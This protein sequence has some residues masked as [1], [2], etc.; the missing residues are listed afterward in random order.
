MNQFKVQSIEIT[1]DYVD[2]FNY[3]SN[4]K[5]LP[6]WT[7]AFDSV[8]G[9]NAVM[10]TPSGVTEITLKVSS[11]RSQGTIDWLMRFPDGSEAKA[12]SR[13]IKLNERRNAYVFILTAPPV[14]L[15]ELEGTL[16]E[17]SKILKEELEHLQAILSQR[18]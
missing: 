14:P 3:I 16:A 17:Q 12:Y 7:N 4:P 5:N 15:E 6:E 13:L 2:A 1:A 11:S 9:D 8:T 18:R 10:K